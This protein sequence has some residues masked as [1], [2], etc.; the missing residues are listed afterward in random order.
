MEFYLLPS[1]HHL[2]ENIIVKCELFFFLQIESIIRI[3]F[4]SQSHV[5]LKKFLKAHTEFSFNIIEFY[6]IKN[7]ILQSLKG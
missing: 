4:S 5:Q 7:I 3:Y 2:T 1:A 6:F